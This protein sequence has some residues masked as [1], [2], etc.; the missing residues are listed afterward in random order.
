ME[1]GT[2][3]TDELPDLRIGPL[4]IPAAHVIASFT[5]ER[6]LIKQIAEEMSAACGEPVE[7]TTAESAFKAISRVAA[8]D[9]LANVVAAAE[10]HAKSVF[11]QQLVL[12]DEPRARDVVIQYARGQKYANAKELVVAAAGFV[13][14]QA[15]RRA[16]LDR[17]FDPTLIALGYQFCSWGRLLACIATSR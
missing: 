14:A 5:D 17:S 16:L 8:A 7:L 6:D 2:G 12:L 11:K 9:F 4:R 15:V 10:A 13:K 1:N 3:T